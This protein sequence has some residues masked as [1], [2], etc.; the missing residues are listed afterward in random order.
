[1]IDYNGI[2]NL[3]KHHIEVVEQDGNYIKYLGKLNN[4]FI[5]NYCKEIKEKFE[6]KEKFKIKKAHGKDYVEINVITG[7]INDD[8]WN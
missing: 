3:L 4:N 2:P 6:E 8:F 7:D 5:F 1:M